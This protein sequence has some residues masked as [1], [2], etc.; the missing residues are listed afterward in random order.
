MNY[1][2]RRLSLFRSLHAPHLRRGEAPLLAGICSRFAQL[3]GLDRILVRVGVGAILIAAAMLSPSLFAVLVGLYGL[4]WFVLPSA[5]DEIIAEQL[6]TRES[7][8]WALIPIVALLIAGLVGVGSLTDLVWIGL[9][10]A[11]LAALL[12][13]LGRRHHR[14]AP[15][16]PA[17]LPATPAAADTEKAAD[18]PEAEI[19][20]MTTPPAEPAPEPVDVRQRPGRR[21]SLGVAG[22]A[23]LGACGV[24]IVSHSVGLLS[25]PLLIAATVGIIVAAGAGCAHL[26]GR[27]GGWMTGLAT[28]I[29]L[30]AVFPLTMLYMVVP[31]SLAW[32]NGSVL[33]LSQSAYRP[34]AVSTDQ[35]AIVGHIGS[36]I[37]PDGPHPS[38]LNVVFG[39]VR[40]YVP[41]GSAVDIVTQLGTGTLSIQASSSF[42]TS[43]AVTIDDFSPQNATSPAASDLVPMGSLVTTGSSSYDAAGTAI[44]SAHVS[45]PFA[46]DI[47]TGIQ[48]RETT[49]HLGARDADTQVVRVHARVG[50]G[51][52]E[53]I[54]SRPHWDG[55][56]K[57]KDGK[58]YFFQDVVCP[59]A[60]PDDCRYDQG[61]ALPGTT[62]WGSSGALYTSDMLTP[63]TTAPDGTQ[64]SGDPQPNPFRTA[65]PHS[66][67]ASGDAPAI[68]GEGDLQ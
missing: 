45:V 17:P 30:V 61:H 67:G 50:I 51:E 57:E 35:G 12:V 58:T 27:N 11:A 39:A 14:D 42:S 56:V 38:D 4:A 40:I 21:L 15:S 5:E 7:L 24:G 46:P 60:N 32:S 36:Y 33:P 55:E 18:A 52:I 64:T 47:S 62:S 25:G 3:S 29:T 43:G 66:D 41:T 1:S 48:A 37:R 20:T 31:P 68:D 16:A 6:L 34:G 28:L 23:L 53:I 8:S 26:M 9:G 22:L 44:P 19:A 63:V 13:A 65:A 10:V 49:V 2:P 54:E 59:T